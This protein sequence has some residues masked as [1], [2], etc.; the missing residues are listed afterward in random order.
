M[1]NVYSNAHIVLA[2][3]HAKN[4]SVGCFHKRAH[5]PT[6]TITL[7]SFGSGGDDEVTVQAM[8]L[9]PSDEHGSLPA[10][11]Q[12]EPLTTRG[13]ALQERVL[14]RRVLHFN[15][16]KMYF[17]CDNGITGEDGSRV[18]ERLCPLPGRK[19]SKNDI[20][21]REIWNSILWRYGDRKFTKV[22][23]KMPALSGLARLFEQRSDAKY[24]A[25]LWSDDL[26]E[27]LAWQCIGSRSLLSDEE[28]TY[29]GPSWSW[30][31]YSGVAATGVRKRG[32]KDMAEIKDWHVEAK[33]DSNPYGEVKDAWIKI[34]APMTTLSPSP[35]E[36]ND[37]EVR[38]NRAGRQPHPRMCTPYSMEKNGNIVCLDREEA[39]ASGEWRQW[40]LEALMLGGYPKN[41]KERLFGEIGDNEEDD[42]VEHPYCLV[43]RKVDDDQG[44][45]RMK[46]VGWMMLDTE[47]AA[48]V[49]ECEESWRTVVLV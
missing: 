40:E 3:N 39:E 18:N 12:N 49:R 35:I 4:N 8:L 31:N 11:F 1:I 47:E 28:S 42:A 21:E 5:I 46:R 22:T 26:I 44:I 48:K 43:V 33:T 32:F 14:A 6:A 16:R 25:G 27:G 36:I 15:T 24:V 10:D 23:D 17:E 20:S 34:R 2:A 9:P 29:M 13:W 37:H 7:P 30:A 19:A 45:W 38:L 41:V